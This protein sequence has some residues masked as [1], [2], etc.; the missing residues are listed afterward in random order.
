[1]D[2]L[3]E[4]MIIGARTMQGWRIKLDVEKEEVT[5]DPSVARLRL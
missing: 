1:M 5:F 3:S 2:K 4:D